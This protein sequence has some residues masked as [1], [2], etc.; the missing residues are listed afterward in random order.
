MKNFYVKTKMSN[1]RKLFLIVILIIVAFFLLFQW[2]NSKVSPKLIYIAQKNLDKYVEGIASDFQ[3]FL[4]ESQEYQDFLEVVLNQ[5]GEIQ[6]VDY[7]ME[8]IY[9]LASQLTEYI[10]QSLKR[11]NKQQMI[12]Y[13]KSDFL[14]DQEDTLILDMPLGL[15]SNSPFLV[16]LGPKIPVVIHFINSV[17]TNVRTRLTNYGINNAMIEVYLNVTISYEV[18]LP[19]TKEEHQKDYELLI[20]SKLIQ[21]KV[22]DW[23]S[24]PYETQSA[25]FELPF[26]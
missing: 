15:V 8:K 20:D 10:E 12:P 22:P 3:I 5:M 6:S 26:K 21:G 18:L 24:K 1:K 11:A 7:Q 23:Y 16:N 17:F 25:F 14:N 13:S 4:D 9:S 2:F 19:I